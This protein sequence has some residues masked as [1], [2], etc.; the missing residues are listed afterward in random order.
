MSAQSANPAKAIDRATRRRLRT[1]AQLLDAARRLIID[2]GYEA[3]TIADIT[4][5]ADVGK[6]TFYLHF[7]DKE[8]LTHALVR[9][10]LEEL[11]DS[12]L[13]RRNQ[14]PDPVSWRAEAVHVI[15]HY[16][17]ANRDLFHI[18]LGGG[19]S[20]Q[21]TQEARDFAAQ[22]ME[23]LL[24]EEVAAGRAM[25]YPPDV[26]AQIQ[27]GAIVQTVIWWLQDAHGYAPDAIADVVIDVLRRGIAG[28]LDAGE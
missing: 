25:P 2:K 12:I 28:A 3:V 19:S 27:T 4:D 13:T 1:R 17:H 21:L 5:A 7:S 22:V 20:A 23:Q 18:L 15:F 11:A 8:D 16:A 24:R 9:D 10:G 26:L 14:A 6:G